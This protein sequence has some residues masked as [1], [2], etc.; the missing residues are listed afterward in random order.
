VACVIVA[1]WDEEGGRPVRN[2]RFALRSRAGHVRRCRCRSNR[3]S[4]KRRACLIAPR[5]FERRR[6]GRIREPCRGSHRRAPPERLR[7][8]IAQKAAHAVT[9]SR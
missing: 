9:M 6:Q 5:R 7:R 1:A 2:G 3:R 4:G 8:Q